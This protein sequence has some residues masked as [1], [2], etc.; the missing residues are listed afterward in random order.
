MA[1]YGTD[2]KL[3]LLLCL[4]RSP[5]RRSA[6]PCRAVLY[7][8]VCGSSTASVFLCFYERVIIMVAFKCVCVCVC[9]CLCV[10]VCCAV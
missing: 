4:S 1:A 5:T 9:L 6:V 7:G 8:A 10:C 2:S 3:L